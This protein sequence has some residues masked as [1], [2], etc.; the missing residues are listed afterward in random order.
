[1]KV[2]R[3]RATIVIV[4]SVLAYNL[5]FSTSR[6]VLA[7]FDTRQFDM[8]KS[9]G[10]YIESIFYLPNQDKETRVSHRQR[11]RQD[12]NADIAGYKDP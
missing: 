3:R 6:S 10:L 9:A 11:I 2:R 1:M 7:N 8:A 12:I 4:F 5:N